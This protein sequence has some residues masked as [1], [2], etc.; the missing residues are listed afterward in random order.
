MYMCIPIASVFLVKLNTM[1]VCV[2]VCVCICVCT[3]A[4]VYLE[5]EFFYWKRSHYEVHAVLNSQSSCLSLPS[6]EILGMYYHT[7]KERERD[8]F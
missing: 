2:C 5:R 7:Q 3:H 8:L 1:C 4:C 6:A